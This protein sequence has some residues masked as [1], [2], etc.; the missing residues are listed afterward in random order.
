VGWDRANGHGL[1]ELKDNTPSKANCME[2]VKQ[3]AKQ[4][5]NTPEI[6]RK[7]YIHP[8]VLESYL[9]GTLQLK[10]TNPSR[11]QQSNKSNTELQLIRFLA[12][13]RRKARSGGTLKASLT[14]SLSAAQARRRSAGH[15]QSVQVI[16]KLNALSKPRLQ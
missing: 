15:R 11:A 3:V 1:Q 6:C 13:R 10:L 9:A 12:G 14:T 8:A 7:C 2:V 16:S 4:L 5:G